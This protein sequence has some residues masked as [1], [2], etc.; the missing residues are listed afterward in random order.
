MC[1]NLEHELA[2]WG[3]KHSHAALGVSLLTLDHWWDFEC[4]DFEG[5]RLTSQVLLFKNPQNIFP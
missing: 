1:A 2:F 3:R 4:R 5:F